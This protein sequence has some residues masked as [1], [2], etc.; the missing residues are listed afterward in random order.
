MA[1]ELPEL[2][3]EMDALAPHLSARTL[4]FHHGTHQRAYVDAVNVAVAG[5]SRA[6][7]GLDRIVRESDGVLYSVAAQAWCHAF[8]WSCLRPGGGGEPGGPVGDAIRASFGTYAEFRRLFRGTALGQFGCGWTWL[9]QDGARLI[10]TATTSAD[11]PLRHGRRALLVCDMF[12]HAYQ[13][14]Y[15]NAPGEYVEAFLD[16]LVNWD[17]VARNLD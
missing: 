15:R 1:I 4:E 9:E 16:H 13:F 6:S 3:Y 14:D 12:E 11:I 17:W 8:Y 10:V 5:T 2:P 7:M